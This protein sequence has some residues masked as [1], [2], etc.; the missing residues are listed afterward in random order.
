MSGSS[1]HRTIKSGFIPGTLKTRKG[2]T[3]T[4]GSSST[5]PD[6]KNRN[7]RFHFSDWRIITAKSASPVR[8]PGSILPTGMAAFIMGSGRSKNEKTPGMSSSGT[9]SIIAFHIK[10]CLTC[11]TF[12][13][14]G[15]PVFGGDFVLE[16]KTVRRFILEYS[17]DV[18]ISMRYN[19]HLN[20][21]VFD[22]L[23]P[24]QP[25]FK[26]NYRFYS[27]DGS[28]DGFTFDDGDFVFQKDVDA[29]ND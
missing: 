9:S 12:D 18:V 13:R 6:V 27:P 28:Y 10:S 15:H 8:R 17:A 1:G 26:G 21:I 16:K 20:M 19:P 29:R 5:S 11:L 7:N 3:P 14:K 4:T 2:N 22:H 24:F 23:E 25:I